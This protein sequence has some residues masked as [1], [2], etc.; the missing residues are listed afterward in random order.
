MLNHI[1]TGILH[2]VVVVQSIY[3]GILLY[4]GSVSTYV[5]KARENSVAQNSGGQVDF[6]SSLPLAAALT[7][8]LLSN[9]WQEHGST[10]INLPAV[11]KQQLCHVQNK[12]LD[13]L[14][15]NPVICMSKYN[16][17]ITL[18]PSKF[19]NI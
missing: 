2:T 17:R 7:A 19:S 13:F 18:Q 3:A 4:C 10:R 9:K 14:N 1:Y 8:D 15:M 12:H 5:V 6:F 16:F 11:K